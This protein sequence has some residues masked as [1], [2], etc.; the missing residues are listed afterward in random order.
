LLDAAIEL[1]NEKLVKSLGMSEPIDPARPLSSY[2]IDSLVAVE[3]R[4][5]ARAQLNVEITALEIVAANTLTGLS[6]MILARL[7]KRN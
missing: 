5:W 2:G 7:L 1:G 4:N 3:F 6:E